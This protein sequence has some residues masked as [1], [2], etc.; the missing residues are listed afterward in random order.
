MANLM[1]HP[2]AHNP[3]KVQSRF[4]NGKRGRVRPFTKVKIKEKTPN[5]R[6]RKCRKLLAPERRCPTYIYFYNKSLE[7]L[8]HD[9]RRKSNKE[10][11]RIIKPMWEQLSDQERENWRKKATEA[12]KNACLVLPSSDTKCFNFAFDG[13]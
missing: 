13:G 4:Q 6:P 8:S 3:S 2:Q 1:K 12:Y 10:K 9:E 11:H 7:R 5:E